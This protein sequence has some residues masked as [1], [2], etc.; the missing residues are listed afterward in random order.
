ML[1]A[2]TCPKVPTFLDRYSA[3]WDWAQSSI[4]FTDARLA[5]LLKRSMSATPEYRCTTM[6]AFVAGVIR[7]STESGS[8]HRVL[9]STSA[10]T[11][12]ALTPRIVDAEATHDKAGVMTS[13]PAPTPH[14]SSAIMRL[15]VPLA[16]GTQ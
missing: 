1:K 10:K 14:A 8:M 9:G 4:S 15:A 2:P 16:A 12:I 13:S 6:I 7:R 5:I 3:P 11:G